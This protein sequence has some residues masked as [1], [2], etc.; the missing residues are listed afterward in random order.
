MTR[1]MTR[2][3]ARPMGAV[4]CVLGESPRWDA[5]REE[6]L[7]IDMMEGVVHAIGA[8]GA[9]ARSGRVAPAVFGLELAD[10]GGYVAV[11]ENAVVHLFADLAGQDR[12]STRLNSSHANISY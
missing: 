1:P 12:K 11:T 4:S 5:D 2:P 8:S 7:C 9:G 10:D 6:L 3:M